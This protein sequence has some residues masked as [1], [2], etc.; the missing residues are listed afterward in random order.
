MTDSDF[1][2][3]AGGLISAALS[4]A[5]G[6]V[7]KKA[8]G[9]ATR[10]E[11]RLANTEFR[12]MARKLFENAE[13]DRKDNREQFAKMQDTIHGVHVDVLNRLK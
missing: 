1:L 11:L 2:K 5:V 3:W 7:W 9:A 6:W 8:D 12:D 10:E 13:A 4:G